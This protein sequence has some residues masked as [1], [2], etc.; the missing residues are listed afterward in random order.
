MTRS[1][2]LI[3][4]AILALALAVVIRVP[5]GSMATARPA[6]EDGHTI[7]VCATLLI[8]DELM[9]SDRYKPDR[10][11]L[12]EEKRNQ[13]QPLMEDLQS[14]SQRGQAAQAAGEDI[15]GLQQE[16]QALQRRLQQA[17]QQ[18]RQE[19]AELMQQ[20]IIDCYGL[21]RTSAKAVAKDLGY[22]YV[23]SSSRPD[24]T[25][26]DNPTGEF[27][28]RPMLVFPEDTDI[29]EEVREDLKLE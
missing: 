9:D 3:P 8:V 17:Q 27:L 13:I 25:M 28:S 14:L 18:A 5:F 2:R 19:I 6:S 29:T 7:A 22:D 12:E 11:A 15:S 24:D 23:V 10:D 20:Q 26:E 21:I 1:S 4:L 16:Y